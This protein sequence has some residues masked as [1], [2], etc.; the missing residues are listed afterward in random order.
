MTGQRN[1]KQFL[2]Y[3]TLS[4]EDYDVVRPMIWARNRRT[5][6]ITSA[7]SAAMGLI[8][9]VVNLLTNSGIWIPYL[10]LFAGSAF[11]FFTLRIIK[12]HKHRASFGMFLCYAEMLLVCAYAGILS[13]QPSNFEIPATSIIVFISMLPLSIDDRPVRMYSFML[14]ESAAYLVVSYF[15]KSSKA[16]SLDLQNTATFVVVGMVL[17]GVICVRNVREIHNSVRV[18]KIQRSIITSLATVVEERDEN[19]GDHIL[20]TGGYIGAL[21][22]AVRHDERYANV[23][24]EFLKNVVIAAPMHDI[25][26]IKIPDAVLNKPGRL[27]AEE[28]ELMKTHSALGE[29]IIRRTMKDASD[30][31]YFTVACNIAR[32]HHERY[33]GKGYPD[34]L[35]GK[36]IPLEARMMAIADVYDALISKRVYKEAYPKE[37]AR[38]IIAEGAGTQFDPD[39]VPLFLEAVR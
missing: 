11:V 2:L 37:E 13:T 30:E 24:M 25:G 16:F 1:F 33:D 9:L 3:C 14:A 15:L 18:E 35:K 34:G 29:D 26:K 10:F 31:S 38:E 12:N 39:L 27:T 6:R 28:Y 20:R 23:S 22:D 19:T 8:F 32:H 17:Y 4:Q 5:L 21:A 36:D 7:L